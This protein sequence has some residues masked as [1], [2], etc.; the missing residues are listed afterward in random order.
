MVFETFKCGQL[1]DEHFTLKISLSPSAIARKSNFCKYRPTFDMVASFI[2]VIYP[3]FSRIAFN[4]SFIKIIHK[5][6]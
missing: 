4:L 3:I 5:N 6:H 2:K 1:D